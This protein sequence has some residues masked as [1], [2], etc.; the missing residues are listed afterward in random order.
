MAKTYSSVAATE[1]RERASE[2]V[3]RVAYGGEEVILTRRGKAVAALVPLAALE[4][5]QRLEDAEDLADARTA[6]EDA[7][8][9]GT[10]SWEVIK[11]DL[12]RA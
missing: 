8:K 6:R 9:H 7:R 3:S 4:A 1:L 12:H 5:L 10:I 11:A 2:I